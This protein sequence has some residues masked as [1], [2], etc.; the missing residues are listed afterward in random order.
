MNKIK[1]EVKLVLKSF[2]PNFMNQNKCYT[3]H[4]INTRYGLF[5]VPADAETIGTRLMKRGHLV[6]IAKQQAIT[7]TY[8]Q[9]FKKFHPFLHYLT[10]VGAPTDESPIN[11]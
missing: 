8:I 1:Q 9:K 7:P 5:L 10:Y 11:S 6:S 3:E 2:Q 4:L